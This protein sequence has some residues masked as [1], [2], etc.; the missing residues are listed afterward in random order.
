[1]SVQHAAGGRRERRERVQPWDDRGSAG[2]GRQGTDLTRRYTRPPNWGW[3]PAADHRASFLVPAPRTALVSGS[4]GWL[5]T[6]GERRT[7]HEIR[8]RLRIPN[9][10]PISGSCHPDHLYDRVTNKD[11]A[12]GTPPASSWPHVRG[13]GPADDERAFAR[14]LRPLKDN[15]HL[16]FALRIHLPDMQ[17]STGVDGDGVNVWIQDGVAS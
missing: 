3:K 16:L 14:H 7:R 13:T 9:L 12:R 11:P 10:G 6:T 8:T 1:M 2:R 4:D 5:P 17:I 15:A